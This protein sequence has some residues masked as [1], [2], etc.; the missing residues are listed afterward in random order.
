MHVCFLIKITYMYLI[1]FTN[2][3]QLEQVVCKVM[4]DHPVDIEQHAVFAF[5]FLAPPAERQRSFSNAD[6]S[7]VHP[8]VKIEGGGLS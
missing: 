5:L 6:L 8:S 7:V 3:K 1:R 2:P 4:K